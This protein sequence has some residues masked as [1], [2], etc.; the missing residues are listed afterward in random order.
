MTVRAVT[1][2]L[3]TFTYKEQ[4]T[5]VT[6]NCQKT[7]TTVNSHQK[8][9]IIKIIGNS[10]STFIKQHLR[11]SEGELLIGAE[12]TSDQNSHLDV[13]SWNVYYCILVLSSVANL[14]LG[15]T[16]RNKIIE[17]EFKESHTPC[18][19]AVS[20]GLWLHLFSSF[21]FLLNTTASRLICQQLFFTCPICEGVRQ[22]L[23]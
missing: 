18:H 7:F 15:N 4:S 20:F 10:H 22:M 16:D 14:P 3:F 11:L 23:K 2:G 19:T 6:G 21:S 17:I 5:Y 9:D 1:V 12:K 13:C 8:D